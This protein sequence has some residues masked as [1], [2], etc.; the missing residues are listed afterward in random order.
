M[1]VTP[2]S[3]RWSE[4]G[5]RRGERRSEAVDEMFFLCFTASDTDPT[6]NKSFTL[7][8]IHTLFRYRPLFS[9]PSYR[10]PSSPPSA[11]HS[12]VYRAITGCD[13]QV[14]S[15]PPTS[16]RAEVDS[17]H[18]FLCLV[19]CFLSIRPV[20]WNINNRVTT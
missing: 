2:L 19:F 11:L 17:G 5:R 20:L 6:V 18:I 14:R 9:F 4:R 15:Q 16:C 7:A 10:M 3:G 8:C 12:H 1:T 13:A